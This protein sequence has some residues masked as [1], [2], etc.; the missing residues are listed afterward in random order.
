MGDTS[1]YLHA[2]QLHQA[3]RSDD[4]SLHSG[5]QR[6]HQRQQLRRDAGEAAIHR[7][8]LQLHQQVAARCCL[9]VVAKLQA[10]AE[11]AAAFGDLSGGSKG[12]GSRCARC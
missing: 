3:C 2:C 7:L 9:Q 11:T 12:R 10:V 6:A 1:T 8:L 5:L 4:V